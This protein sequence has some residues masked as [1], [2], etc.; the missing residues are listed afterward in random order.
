[1][2]NA[3]RDQRFS[4][5]E[6]SETAFYRRS[7]IWD[8]RLGTGRQRE[9]TAY[10]IAALAIL[11]SIVSI[12][13]IIYVASRSHIQPYIVEVDK[14]GEVRLVGEVSEREWSLKDSSK[15]RELEHWIK[16]LR[17]MSTDRLVVMD[18]F[19]FVR[20]HISEGATPKLALYFEEEDPWARFGKEQR[21]VRII[22]HT[23]IRDSEKA[24]RVEWKEEIFR[25]NVRVGEEHYVGEF[26]LH[27][28][29]P[30]TE[31]ELLHNHLGVYI[32]F[33]DIARKRET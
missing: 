14:Q 9:R 11:T 1:M 30:E 20:T 8:D 28:K 24:Y 12:A 3:A 25:D 22:S 17:S 10:Q 21:I 29:P 13:G 19:T 15:Q 5:S 18:N 32:T 6:E 31:A 2:R 26:H 4:A 27:I 7:Q 33:F 23:A 16:N